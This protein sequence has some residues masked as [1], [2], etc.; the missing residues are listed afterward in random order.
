MVNRKL[1]T[2]VNATVVTIVTEVPV[3]AVVPVVPV[4]LRDSQDLDDTP[5]IY[6]YNIFFLNIPF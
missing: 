5:Q 1:V 4:K 2:V 3:A 6:L